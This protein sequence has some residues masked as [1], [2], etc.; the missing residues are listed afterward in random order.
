MSHI[1]RVIGTTTPAG[2]PLKWALFSQL[3]LMVYLQVVEWIPLGRWNNITNGNGQEALT[4]FSLCCRR[5]FSSISIETLAVAGARGARAL[6]ALVL[7]RGDIFVGSVL[8]CSLTP[9]HAILRA[10]VWE[11]V[12]V[13]SCHRRASHSRC[14]AHRHIGTFD[15]S[16]FQFCYCDSRRVSKPL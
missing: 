1:A 8:P 6:W 3:F 2:K 11:H 7:S 4:S 10:L 14:R 5:L 16:A 13:S 12:Q 15:R 9:I